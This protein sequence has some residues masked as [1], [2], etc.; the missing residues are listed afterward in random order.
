MYERHGDEKHMLQSKLKR[1]DHLSRWHHDS[2]RSMSNKGMGGQPSSYG[3]KNAAL[4]NKDKF[5]KYKTLHRNKGHLDFDEGRW[6]VQM[7]ASD[8][9]SS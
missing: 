4:E 7:R 5:L 8:E 1:P 9:S 3:K 2:Q 6:E